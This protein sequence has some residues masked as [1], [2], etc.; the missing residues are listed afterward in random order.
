MSM[1]DTLT[2][3]LHSLLSS[4]ATVPL[5]YV[6]MCGLLLLLGFKQYRNIDDRLR[7]VD[8]IAPALRDIRS[9]IRSMWS[10]T[11]MR[12]WTLEA[13]KKLRDSGVN[14]SLPNPYEIQPSW[15]KSQA[16]NSAPQPIQRTTLTQPQLDTNSLRLL[17]TLSLG[18]PGPYP[19]LLSPLSFLPQESS[20]INSVNRSSP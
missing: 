11:H 2:K 7:S 18:K 9:E 13:E 10:P 15:Q 19:S 14:V 17:G 6:V 4:K 5:G 12:I 1:P 3:I 8:S 20:R 16:F